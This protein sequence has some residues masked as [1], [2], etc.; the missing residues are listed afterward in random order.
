[1]LTTAV[2]DE[3]LLKQCISTFFDPSSRDNST[4]RQALSYFL[5]V[6]AHSRRE[7][8]QRVANVAP[9][10]MHAV[11]DLA[12][13]MDEE[14]EMVGVSV[15]GGMLVDWTDARKLV[16]L[17]DARAGWDEAGGGAETKMV[18]TGI[19]LGLAEGLLEK[20]LGH[21]CSSKFLRPLCPLLHFPHPNYR[22]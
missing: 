22:R 12:D 14:E 17:D 19:H 9:A 1:M 16:V 10:V 15:V 6:Y 2:S 3:D 8:M 21:G 11:V 4:V 18:D 7:N 20:I 5:P 13:E